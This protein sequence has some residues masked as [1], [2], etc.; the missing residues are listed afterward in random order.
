[1]IW[2]GMF[3]GLVLAFF[4][5]VFGSGAAEAAKM[6]L[7]Q[8]ERYKLVAGNPAAP[9]RHRLTLKQVING[10][11]LRGCAWCDNV[12]IKFSDFLKVQYDR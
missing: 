11:E 9:C 2:L 8:G 6:A 5:W 7:H 3:I 4:I 1:M 12:Y 10:Y